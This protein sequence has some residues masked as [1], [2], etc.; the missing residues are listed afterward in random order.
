MALGCVSPRS[1]PPPPP[2]VTGMSFPEA[3]LAVEAWAVESGLGTV[4]G[5]E[6]SAGGGGGATAVAALST[7]MPSRRLPYYAASSW[8]TDRNGYPVRV[9]VIGRPQHLEWW[10]ELVAR[11]DATT[12]EEDAAGIEALRSAVDWP[13]CIEFQLIAQD[14]C[15]LSPDEQETWCG[16]PT[17]NP[18][19]VELW[20]TCIDPPPQRI[21]IAVPE[22]S[23]MLG[24]FAGLLLLAP[25]GRRRHAGS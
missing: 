11:P 23:R 13:G 2:N 25:L 16:N 14:G 20:G 19:N 8:E 15:L 17:G 22:P 18:S 10:Q 12:P 1:E 7:T 21:P 3:R 4:L 6:D 5:G 9:R 24:L